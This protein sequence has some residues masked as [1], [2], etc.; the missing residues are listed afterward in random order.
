[1]NKI[2]VDINVIVYSIDEDSKFHTISRNLLQNPENILYTT[3]KNLSEF[4]VVLTRGLEVPVTIENALEALT[5]LISSFTIL[6]P[7]EASFNI[8]QELLLK[9]KPKGL[10]IHD[11]EIISI[12]LQ[13]GIN[14]IATINAIDFKG[15]S[16]IEIVPLWQQ[17]APGQRVE[18]RPLL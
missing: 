12:G 6:Y 17:E 13:N 4:L 18:R 2:I 16:E 11:F 15:I 8:L 3:S 10:K 5:N 9:Y 7:S 1:M 14:N